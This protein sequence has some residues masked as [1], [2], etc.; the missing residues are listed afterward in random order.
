MYVD[1]S[2]IRNHWDAWISTIYLASR[3]MH[4]VLYLPQLTDMYPKKVGNAYSVPYAQKVWLYKDF[5]ALLQCLR[6]SLMAFARFRSLLPYSTVLNRGWEGSG[7]GG[8][9]SSPCRIIKHD[10]NDIHPVIF[11]ATRYVW[12]RSCYLSYSTAKR[13]CTLQRLEREGWCTL[14]SFAPHERSTADKQ[15]CCWFRQY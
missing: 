11:L 14:Q 4:C 12:S 1:K 8:G 9:M 15:F 3:E 10:R 5:S 2:I 7:G 6:Y 13:V